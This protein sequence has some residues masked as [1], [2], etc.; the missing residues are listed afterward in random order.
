[1]SIITGKPLEFRADQRAFAMF[2][3]LLVIGLSPAIALAEPFDSVLRW[4]GIS[5][6]VQCPNDGSLNTLTVQPSG[7]SLPQANV[8]IHQEI[9]GSVSDARLS[10]LDGD[11]SPELYVFISASGS[12]SYGEL[13][14]WSVNKGKSLG[15]IY[16]PPLSDDPVSSEGYRGHDVFYTAG[17]RLI[18][19]FPVYRPGDGNANPTGGMRVLRYH[20]VA[21]EAGWILR[22]DSGCD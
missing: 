12:G 14:A 8:P 5:F 21:G 4:D 6:R 10:D 20:L 2:A 22:S 18:R 16:L 17:N 3:L 11:G 19:K 1:M 7:L 13:L 15:E 9:D